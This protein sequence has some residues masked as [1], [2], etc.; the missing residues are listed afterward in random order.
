MVNKND[1]IEYVCATPI[2]VT[3]K[4]KISFGESTIIRPERNLIVVKK[5]KRN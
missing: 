4:G 5:Q 1:E 2:V 3:K